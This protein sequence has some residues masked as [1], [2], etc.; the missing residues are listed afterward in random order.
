MIIFTVAYCPDISQESCQQITDSVT[1][2]MV[3]DSEPSGQYDIS[4]AIEAV[5]NEDDIKYLEDLN[6]DY[7]EI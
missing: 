4:M 7:I 6:V 1:P 5:S 3:S 2:S